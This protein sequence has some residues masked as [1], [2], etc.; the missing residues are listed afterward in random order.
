MADCIIRIIAS[1]GFLHRVLNFVYVY[2]L[3]RVVYLLDRVET[4]R[5]ATVPC[6]ILIRLKYKNSFK[7]ILYVTCRSASQHKDMRAAGGI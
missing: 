2:F 7:K 3:H 6:N 5:K 1:F 4:P